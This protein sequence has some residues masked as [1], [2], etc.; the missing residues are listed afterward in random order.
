[1]FSGQRDRRAPILRRQW[2]VSLRRSQTPRAA[3]ALIRK[4]SAEWHIDPNRIGMVGFSAGAMLTMA[5]T[6][7][8]ED[9]KP[10]FIGNI[11]GPLAPL[12]VP[13][14]APPL[15]IAL[16]ADDPFFANGG[17]GLIDS[18]RPRSGPSNSI[19]MNRVAMASGCTRRKLRAPV[20]FDAFVRWLGMHGMLKVTGPGS[21]RQV[22]VDIRTVAIQSSR[23]RS[24]PGLVRGPQ[25]DHAAPY[26]SSAPSQTDASL[27]LPHIHR[28]V[29]T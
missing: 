13:A 27:S 2:P 12:T 29:F 7:A 20:W 1:M 18:W 22:I 10:A 4:R 23:S 3:F 9:A 8:G 25:S 17:Y 15:F 16:A 19:F 24:P 6:L 26:V 21:E 11:Y 14:D 28:L 5:T